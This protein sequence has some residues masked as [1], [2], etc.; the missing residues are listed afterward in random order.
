[1]P[2]V[3]RRCASRQPKPSHSSGTRRY[4]FAR[5]VVDRRFASTPPLEHGRA[6]IT[7]RTSPVRSQVAG[8]QRA[9]YDAEGAATALPNQHGTAVR[10]MLCQEKRDTRPAWSEADTTRFDSPGN[11][12]A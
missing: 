11:L 1:M 2:A 4:P 8:A 5:Q 3:R 7:R 6:L 9:F 12:S 10:F